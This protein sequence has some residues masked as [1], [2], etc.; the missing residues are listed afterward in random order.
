MFFKNIKSWGLFWQVAK[1]SP[2]DL[3]FLKNILAFPE[4]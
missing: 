4:F 3:I 2:Q 1:K